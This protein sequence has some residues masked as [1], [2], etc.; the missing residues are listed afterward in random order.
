MN[1]RFV[2]KLYRMFKLYS[3]FWE[4]GH[5][6]TAFCQYHFAFTKVVNILS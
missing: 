3:V 5:S 4:V 1:I 2:A 6:V